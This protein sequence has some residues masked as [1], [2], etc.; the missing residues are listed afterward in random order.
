MPH[1]SH[2]RPRHVPTQPLRRRWR[3]VS[4]TIQEGDP[5]SRLPHLEPER[6]SHCLCHRPRPS[7][8]SPPQRTNDPAPIGR[9]HRCYSDQACQE[10]AGGVAESG[11]FSHF[12][13]K[14]IEICC[15]SGRAYLEAAFSGWCSS[16]PGSA[17]RCSGP[18]PGSYFP[19]K[20]L[21]FS[22]FR[23]YCS[24]VSWKASTFILQVDLLFQF[25][26]LLL[27]KKPNFLQSFWSLNVWIEWNWEKTK[28]HYVVG[29]VNEIR[30]PHYKISII[31]YLSRIVFLA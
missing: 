14:G 23:F 22:C 13:D 19:I 16:T 15:C 5:L 4:G 8:P 20:F 12:W 27:H 1:V 24:I 11:A 2:P 10:V 21:P 28:D 17:W 25:F 7:P 6:W 9:R 26:L 30:W 3:P 18:P 31:S 29:W